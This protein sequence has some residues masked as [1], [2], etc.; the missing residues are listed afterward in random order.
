MDRE[1]P[2]VIEAELAATRMS[3]VAKLDAAESK[4]VGAVKEVISTLEGDAK[5]VQAAVT[6]TVGAV[7]EEAVAGLREMLGQLDPT[8]CIRRNPW[9]AVGGSVMG[10][11]V[12]GLFAFRD[13]R[14]RHVTAAA[15][16]T[17]TRDTLDV[18]TRPAG[19]GM[20][21]GFFDRIAETFQ[22]ELTRAGRDVADTLS[23]ALKDQIATLKTAVFH[24][25]TEGANQLRENLTEKVATLIPSVGGAETNA[26]PQTA[27]GPTASNTGCYAG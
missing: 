22:A 2:D 16:G 12:V 21:G 3:L 26:A 8:P 14:P 19:A 20:F 9:A 13:Y 25:V 18:G 15:K 5:S 1:S 24:Q 10:G 27:A 6:D 7:R 11:I 4:T 17:D 23:S